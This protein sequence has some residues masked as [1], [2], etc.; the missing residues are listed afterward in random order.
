MQVLKL[1]K[2]V[3]LKVNIDK[4]EFYVQKT[5][6]FYFIISIKTIQIFLLEVSTIINWAQP[7]VLIIF[8]CFL[9]LINFIE[10]LSKKF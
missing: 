4:S 7:I 5:K 1:L 6:F 2:K 10:L 9:D 8:D 3:T